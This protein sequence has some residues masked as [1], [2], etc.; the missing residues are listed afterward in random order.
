MARCSSYVFDPGTVVMPVNPG[1]TSL[2]TVAASVAEL[3]RAA[4][5]YVPTLP[6]T[7]AI[8]YAMDI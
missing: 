5:L 7:T 8:S 3:A 6:D 1:D 2:H 4:G